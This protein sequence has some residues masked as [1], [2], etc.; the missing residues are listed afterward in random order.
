MPQQFAQDGLSPFA[1]G[2]YRPRVSLK[3]IL[4][5]FAVLSA[6]LAYQVHWRGERREAVAWIEQ[7]RSG[8]WGGM[9]PLDGLVTD[10]VTGAVSVDRSRHVPL[11]VRLTR[12]PEVHRVILEKTKLTSTDIHMLDSLG[13]L[14]PESRGVHISWPEGTQT[15]PPPDREAFFRAP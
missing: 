7:H 8:V 2:W 10:P 15:W 9:L 12:S 11:M 13:S 3:A 6:W 4:I 5:L 14:F 1:A